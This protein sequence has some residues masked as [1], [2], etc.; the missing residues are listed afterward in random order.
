MADR[1]FTVDNREPWRLSYRL[2][3]VGGGSV[4]RGAARARFVYAKT[5]ATDEAVSELYDRYLKG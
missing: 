5:L 1:G 2:G 3:L 4:V